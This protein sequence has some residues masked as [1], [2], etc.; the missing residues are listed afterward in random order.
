MLSV[1]TVIPPYPIAER[2][3]GHRKRYARAALMKPPGDDQ[4]GVLLV[5][6]LVPAY[7]DQ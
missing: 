2:R 4:S 6:L 5:G 1:D 3:G 7:R